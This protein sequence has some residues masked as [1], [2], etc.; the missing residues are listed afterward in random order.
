MA[1]LF[2]EPPHC[3]NALKH[4]RG[5]EDASLALSVTDYLRF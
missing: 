4:P 2:T 5:M 1:M 3:G